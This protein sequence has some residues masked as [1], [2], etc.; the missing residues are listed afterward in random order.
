MR[1]ILISISLLFSM[2]LSQ[3]PHAEIYKTVDKSGRTVYT[4]VPPANS[5]AKPVELKSINSLPPT[6]VS[7]NNPPTQTL[8]ALRHYEIQITSPANGTTLLANERS[9]G[10]AVELNQSLQNGEQLIYKL[11]GA[12]I[13]KTK[14]ISI[15]L[16]EPPRGE[17]VL[18][19]EVVD[20][21]GK[22]LAQSNPVTLLVIR[23]IIKQKK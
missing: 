19:V 17:H 10:I 13:E 2:A 4:D 16:S 3:S 20:G 14:E 5:D 15:T 12:T 18:T 1:Q 11:D 6:E 23:P 9:V 22:S 21:D 7:P 8:S